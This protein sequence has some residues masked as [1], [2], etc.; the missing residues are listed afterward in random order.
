M[1]IINEYRLYNGL[2]V[3]AQPIDSLR[4]VSVGVWVAT[5]SLK[6]TER[7]AGLSHFIEHMLFKGTE[8]RTAQQI[9]QEMDDIGAQ[10]NAFTSRDCTCYYVK[11]TGEHLAKAV[12]MLSDMILCP[13]F[14][15]EEMEREKNVVLEEILMAEDAPEDVVFELLSRAAFGDAPMARPVLGSKQSVAAFTPDDLRQYMKQH[16]CAENLLLSVAGSFDEKE[17]LDLATRYFGE[18]APSGAED[19]YPAA[20]T[21]SRKKVLAASKDIEQAHIALMFPAYGSRDERYFPLSVLNNALGGYMSSRLFQR[22][23]EQSG[24]AYAVYSY[25][26]PCLDSGALAIYVGTGAAQAER[27]V[28]E[29]LEEVRLLREK[30]LREDEFIRSRNQLRGSLILSGESSTSRMTSVGK[31]TLLFGKARGEEDVLALLDA[32]TPER[33]QAILE[34]VFDE[35]ALCAGLVGRDA[36][37]LERLGELW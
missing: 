22:I 20:P 18:V 24:L 33:I 21:R 25:V 6:E 31:Q 12:D 9:A 1:N 5:G 16:Y 7:E 10:M 32:V 28:S 23:R 35:A 26:Q 4:S 27:L 14:D 37:A 8:N 11:A 19:A 3:V 13:R 15:A 29:L 36:A 30:G 17:L 2:R 34:D